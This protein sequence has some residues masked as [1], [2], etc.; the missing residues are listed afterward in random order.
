[1]EIQLT[2]FLSEAKRANA[3]ERD[4]HSNQNGK[5]LPVFEKMRAAQND[6]AA[7]RNKVGRGNN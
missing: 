2:D 5:A 7:E 1:M 3:K 4:R 6:G